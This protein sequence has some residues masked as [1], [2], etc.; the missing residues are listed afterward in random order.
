MKPF[1]HV[2]LPFVALATL[3]L[4]APSPSGAQIVPDATLP[5]N[6]TVSQQGSAL[7]I[8][9]GTSAGGNLFHSF[10]EFSLPKDT[11]AH[12]NSAPAIENIFTRVTGGKVSNIDGTLRANGGANLFLL[13]PNGII[14]GPNAKLNIGGSFFASTGE[15]FNFAD[16]SV[17]SAKDTAAKPVLT[18]SVPVGLQLGQNPGRIVNQSVAANSTGKTVGLSVLPGK[19][20]ALVGGEVS[21]AGGHVTVAGGR[22]ELA[23]VGENSSVSI[24]ATGSSLALGYEGVRDFRDVGLTQGAMVDASGTPS[25]AVM[26]RGRAVQVMSGSRI[27]ALNSG[28]QAG[29]DININAS[30]SLELVGTGNLAKDTVTINETDFSNPL[31]L[32]TGLFSVTSGARA[33]G[34][35]EIN[36]PLLSERN[37]AVIGTYTSGTGRGGDVTVNAPESVEI[38][39]SRL[40]TYTVLDSPG[41]SGNLTVNTGR[42]SVK[43]VG[44]V[45]A[46]TNGAGQGGDLTVN[47]SD[48]IEVL[49]NNVL[50]VVRSDGTPLFISSVLFAATTGAGNAGEMRLN[51]GRLIARN[52][53]AIA[54]NS[55][56]AGRPGNAIINATQSVELSGKTRDAFAFPTTLLA[57][58]TPLAT[59]TGGGNVTISTGKLI[60]R[61]GAIITMSNLSPGSGGSLEVIADT[62]LLDNK[63]S[64]AAETAFGEGGNITLR[65]RSLQLRNSSTISV[66]AGSAKNPFGLPPDLAAFYA[67]QVTG[68]GDGGNIIINTDTLAALENS[69]IAA[70]AQEG[71]GGRV[72]IAAQGVF[73][74]RES[75]ITATSARGAE[76]SGVVEI[77]TPNTDLKSG[78]VELAQNP[79]DPNQQIAGGCETDRGNT[80]TVIG[81]G[82][83][84]E[85][86][87]QPL[88]GSTVWRDVRDFSETDSPPP[89]SEDNRLQSA[90][91][92]LVGVPAGE[93]GKILVKKPLQEATAV[94]VRPDG[95]VELVA[96][97]ARANSWQPQGC[98]KR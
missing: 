8:E 13:N 77:Q 72:S 26:V 59:G 33:S 81:R 3:S 68:A 11:E 38:S 14:F 88:L 28:S 94:V 30:Q 47:A 97:V 25:S 46:S 29:G 31:E 83:L 49:G 90:V 69:T 93:S 9:G 44:Y 20:L 86:P 5:N 18:V 39:A 15:R 4:L 71:R 21:L 22:I 2:R 73:L 23:G 32:P 80:F 63:A 53:A 19:T 42:L 54:P 48:S 16:G 91:P 61:D 7:K 55:G 65:S 41:S 6:S 51:T 37:S 62:I 74:S 10:R 87:T 52:G 34:N 17:F 66:T 82:G 89:A 98:T 96:T 45:S 79:I 60:V 24:S 58:T 1:Y 95:V 67:A 76:F 64:I 12:F 84:P 27:Y 75:A 70:N 50:V 43:D 40:E 35:V 56:G 92:A 36:A 57:A 85:D 78:L